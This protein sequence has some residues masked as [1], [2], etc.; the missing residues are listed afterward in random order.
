MVFLGLG[1]EIKKL[2]KLRDG[3]TSHGGKA[4]DNMKVNRKHKYF[5][6]C[7][8]ISRRKILLLRDIGKYPSSHYQILGS[9]G[10]FDK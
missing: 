2:T 7:V 4:P 3:K 8:D 6:S 9:E 10:I 1:G 5:A